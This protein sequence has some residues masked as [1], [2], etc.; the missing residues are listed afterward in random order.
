MRQAVPS[1]RPL[2]MV[3]AKKGPHGQ[4]PDL[5][6]WRTPTHPDTWN[7]RIGQRQQKVNAALHA[8]PR[9]YGHQRKWLGGQVWNEEKPG[10]FQDQ[11]DIFMFPCQ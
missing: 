9:P 1:L 2:D 11:T 7:G 6:A 4:S 5:P 10:K 3:L 8:K